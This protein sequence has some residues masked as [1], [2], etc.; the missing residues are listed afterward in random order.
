MKASSQ[1]AWEPKIGTLRRFHVGFTYWKNNLFR[2]WKRSWIARGL[3]QSMSFRH[4]FHRG[5]LA[6][7]RMPTAG[8][9]QRWVSSWWAPPSQAPQSSPWLFSRKVCS[10]VIGSLILGVHTGEVEHVGAGEA[11]SGKKIA[12]HAQIPSLDTSERRL[13]RGR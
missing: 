11:H 8:T 10:G 6:S 4:T 13:L 7:P 12:S 9:W 5:L 1:P 3:E 2:R